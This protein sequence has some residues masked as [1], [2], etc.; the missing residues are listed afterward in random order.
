MKK[1]KSGISLIVLVITIIVMIILAAAIIISLNNAG[2]IENA[3]KAKEESNLA[4]IKTAADLIYS[5]YILDESTLPEGTTVGDY[6]TQKLVSNGTIKGK[7][8]DYY[9]EICDNETVVVKV[10]TTADKYYK[11][12]IEAGDKIEYEATGTNCSKDYWYVLG[13]DKNNQL[14]ITVDA[15]LA[16]EEATLTLDNYKNSIAMLNE[17]CEKYGK[18]KGATGARS[19]NIDDIFKVL[20]YTPGKNDG[21]N[22]CTITYYWDGSNKPYYECSNGQKGYYSNSS[23]SWLDEND[24][25]HTSQKST[26]A[27]P[28]NR[29]KICTIKIKNDGYCNISR[30]LLNYDET[31]KKYILLYGIGPMT[32]GFG[33]MFSDYFVANKGSVLHRNGYLCQGLYSKDMTQ[34]SEDIGPC[35]LLYSGKAN[36]Y[37]R[38]VV[39]LDKSILLEGNKTDGWKIQ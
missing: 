10:G 18:G 31:S 4:N 26:N 32:Q 30:E 25:Y 35:D 36:S 38:P 13:I 27:T 5:G 34:Y 33:I 8:E 20:G 17:K 29:E 21:G 7:N 28:E 9:I 12:E 3:G 14:L 23:L 22:G 1:Q 11:G 16:I 19:I 6:I 24:V 2:I 15:D 39:S 37:I